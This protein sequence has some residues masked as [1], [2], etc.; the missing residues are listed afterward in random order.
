MIYIRQVSAMQLKKLCRKCCRL[1]AAHVLEATKNETPKLKDY[2]I[3][4]EFGDVFPNEISGLP[5][6][7]EIDFTIDLV[8]GAAPV[9]KTSYNMSTPEL[10]ELKM[11][12]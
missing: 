10:L 12:L 7:R 3:L 8:P 9:C 1:Y 6:K 2:P 11:Q 4:Q 5:P